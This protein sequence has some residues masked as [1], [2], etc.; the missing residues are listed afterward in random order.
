M[1][2]LLMGLKTVS[3]RDLQARIGQ[4]TVVDVN[5]HP[6]WLKARVPGALHLGV[7]AGFDVGGLPQDRAA[8][9]VFYCS[10]PMCLKAPQAARRAAKLGYTDVRVMPAGI[11]GWTDAGL[12]VESGPAAGQ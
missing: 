7:G 8:P 5:A 3:P 1:F 9:L 10:N 4:I 11:T 6:S 12:P 2:A